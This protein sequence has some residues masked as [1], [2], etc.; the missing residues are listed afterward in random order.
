M[1]RADDSIQLE[2]D[3]PGSKSNEC[4][5]SKGTDHSNNEQFHENQ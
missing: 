2:S 5:E 1:K 4:D 3:K